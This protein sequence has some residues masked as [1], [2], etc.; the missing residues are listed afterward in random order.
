MR[1]ATEF[2]QRVGGKWHGRSGVAPCPVCQ[3]ERRRDQCA[4]SISSDG[5]RLLLHCHKKGC[6][7]RDI[8]LAAGLPLSGEHGAAQ[9]PGADRIAANLPRANSLWERAKPIHGTPGEAYYRSRGITCRLPE[10]LRWGTGVWHGPSQ[11]LLPAIVARVT[12]GAVHR[13]YLNKAGGK[14][15]QHAKLMLGSTAGG[16]VP[17]A[18]HEGALVVCEGLENG[19]SLL[20]GILDE[21]ATV[22]AALSASGLRSVRL[23]T[24]PGRLIIAMDNDKAGV[25]AAVSLASRAHG[26]GWNVFKLSPPPGRDWN[27]VL[28]QKRRA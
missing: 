3:P 18:E 14:L 19:L 4:L 1:E 22:W 9:S 21:P 28:L 25:N 20:C 13:T 15:E 24:R 12:T 7:F 5:T 23:P 10:T 8:M 17:L 27:D 6:P 16:A 2:C 11:S 26:C